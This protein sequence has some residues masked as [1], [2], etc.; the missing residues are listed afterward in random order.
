VRQTIIALFCAAA[1]AGCEDTA[2]GPA[3]AGTPGVP[4]QKGRSYYLDHGYVAEALG[5]GNQAMALAVAGQGEAARTSFVRSTETLAS[6]LTLH[7]QY[8][9]ERAENQQAAATVLTLGIGIVGAVAAGRASGNATSTAELNRINAAFSD[10]VDATGSFGQFLNEQI[11][12]GE[13]GSSAVGRVDRDRWRSVVV[14]NHRYVRSIVTIRN[15]TSG[16]YCTGFFVDP[17]VVMTAAHC[18]RL[19]EALGA[20]RDMPQQGKNFMTGTREFLKIDYQF[21]H[22]RW[23]GDVN[24][25]GAFDI[26][27]LLMEKP[28]QDWL[29]VSTAP[30][31]PGTE[32]IAMGY[33]GDLNKGYF[34]QIDY[35]CRASSVR[36]DNSLASSCVIWRG[37][38]GGP[39]FTAGA[40]PRVVGVNSSGYLR[41]DRSEDDTF[42]ASTREAVAMFDEVAAHP[43]AAGKITRNPF[44]N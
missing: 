27:F 12:Q 7:R 42:S 35:G 24:R 1:L 17:H 13:I 25:T 22:G 32:L 30:V 14:S 31:R 5:H 3:G 39:I 36:A 6:G 10:F 18:F 34:L 19:G 33:S 23:D 20:Y 40:N 28:S 43:A 15:Q 4:V 11:R 37:N 44:R 26:A 41:R 2:G 16:R 9:S 29:P 38:S 8:A 21:S